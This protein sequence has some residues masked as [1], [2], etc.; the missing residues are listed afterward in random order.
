MD[1]FYKRWLR[2]DSKANKSV[3]NAKEQ[4]LLEG[5]EGQST[6]NERG[7]NDNVD[8]EADDTQD[9]AIVSKPS[10]I[11]FE[12]KDFSLVVEKGFHKRQK[13]F[14]LQDHM[15]YFKIVPKNS[16]KHLPLLTDIF[17]FLHAG[18]LHIL[19]SIKQFYKS[20]E[21]NIAYLTLHQEPMVSALNTGD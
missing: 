15:F 13:N 11:S 20:E 12:N 19:D 3:N 8:N 18:F 7:T 5:N 10:D 2:S 1:S 4:S 9:D 14:R 17:D 21:K 16:N 6:E